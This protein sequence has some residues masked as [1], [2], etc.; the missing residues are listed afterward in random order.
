MNKRK[1]DR[2]KSESHATKIAH[3]I[4]QI[5]K[6]EGRA[7]VSVRDLA[8]QLGMSRQTVNKY[9]GILVSD[10]GSE[11]RAEDGSTIQIDRGG[12]RTGG[13]FVCVSKGKYPNCGKSEL[14]INSELLSELGW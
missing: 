8:A 7:K 3:Y 4:A 11:I 14:V 9:M 2:T 6:A 12:R 1:G 13:V 5:C 10:L